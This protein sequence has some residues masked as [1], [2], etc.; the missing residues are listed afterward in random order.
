MF[1]E[2]S[3]S[4]KT[5]TAPGAERRSH[6]ERDDTRPP[7]VELD[8][9][10]DPLRLA[11]GPTE[12]VDMPAGWTWSRTPPALPL[13]PSALTCFPLLFPTPRNPCPLSRSTGPTLSFGA[14]RGLT[15][16]TSPAAGRMRLRHNGQRRQYL[17]TRNA[18]KCTSAAD[19]PVRSPNSSKRRH[20]SV[21]DLRRFSGQTRGSTEPPRRSRHRPG[22][23]R[24]QGKCGALDRRMRR[25][26]N[27]KAVP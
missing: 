2:V 13:L 19:L 24:R 1:G 27:R 3:V 25:P 23:P 11:C 14:A 9:G 10:R 21:T 26:R 20:R 7:P 16:C 6:R 5:V 18:F 22:C 17:K 15:R 8:P 4:A 12:R